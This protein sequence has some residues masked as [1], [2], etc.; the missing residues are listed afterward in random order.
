MVCGLL[1]AGSPGREHAGCFGLPLPPLLPSSPTIVPVSS[2][3]R[4]KVHYCRV[5]AELLEQGRG[6]QNLA[7]TDLV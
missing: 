7:E 3:Q 5:P 1:G 4:P 2:S 6:N